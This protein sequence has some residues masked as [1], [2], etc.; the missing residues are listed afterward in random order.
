MDEEIYPMSSTERFLVLVVFGLWLFAVIN[1][2]RKLEKI[3]NPPSIVMSYA[4]RKT[5]ISNVSVGADSTS[6]NSKG[7]V[8][9]SSSNL[10][11]SNSEPTIDQ[12]ERKTDLIRS[13]SETLISARPSIGQQAAT[14]D[15][16]V[17]STENPSELNKFRKPM[18]KA[19]SLQR[20]GPVPF[21]YPRRLP[22]IVRRSLLDL[23]RRAQFS[24]TLSQHSSNSSPKRFDEPGHFARNHF[25]ALKKTYQRAN[26]IDDDEDYQRGFFREKNKVSLDE[27]LSSRLGSTPV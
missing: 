20:T 8:N 15:F 22:S 24:R 14:S 3:C 25:P 17:E 9:G 6:K 26:A 7:K 4:A 5:T 23:H 19:M 16:I 1:L 12:N 2:A 18:E 21:L 11:R 13:P 27:F 10:V